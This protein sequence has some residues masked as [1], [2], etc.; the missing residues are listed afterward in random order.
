[1]VEGKEVDRNKQIKTKNI[2]TN[3]PHS[4]KK[5]KWDHFLDKKVRIDA[6]VVIKFSENVVFEHVEC[7]ESIH[8]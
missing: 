5:V 8:M 4:L 7:K 3:T 1:M 2:N 6:N